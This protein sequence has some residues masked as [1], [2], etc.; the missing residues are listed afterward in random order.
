MENFKPGDVGGQMRR[1]FESKYFKNSS[2]L[3]EFLSYVVNET[4]A[5]RGSE[6]KEYSIAVNALRKPAKFD[7]QLDSSVRIHAGRLR[8]ALKEYYG[9]EGMNDP[10]LITIPK[11]TYVPLF[12]NKS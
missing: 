4:L 12:T 11:G 5:G 7:Q 8:R 3:I 2:V 1:V 10:I 6:L 9:E